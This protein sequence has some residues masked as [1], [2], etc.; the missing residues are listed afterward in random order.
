MSEH[1][2]HDACHHTHDHGHHHHRA[3]RSY[4]VAFWANLLFAIIEI[5]GGLLTQ[6][7]AITA[8]AVHDLGDATSIGVAWY[9]EKYSKKARDNA[10]NFGY[11]RFSLLAALFSGLV[12]V[13]G[14][15]GIAYHA[16]L[17]FSEP[18]QPATLGMLGLAV[19]GVV[20][21]GGSAL[22]IGAFGKNDGHTHSEK[23]LTWHFLEDLFGWVIVLIGAI[24]I[25]FTHWAWVDPLLALGLAIFIS[26][27]VIKN[28][29][30]TLFLL[31]QGRPR[32][33]DVRGLKEKVLAVKGV[34]EM[35][36]LQI[37]SL[38]GQESVLSM[39]VHLHAVEDRHEVEA[40]KDS[41]RSI[42]VRY[43]A[44][45]TTIETCLAE[46]CHSHGFKNHSSGDV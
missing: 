11:R 22:A 35:D 44:V 23:I 28:L 1:K 2:H 40:I 18:Q 43:G 4:A 29:K 21:N 10:F 39:R 31:L 26:W 8:D 32:G 34:A 9:L 16:L 7:L 20:V 41:V 42:S 45:Q 12:I 3:G 5:I 17:R 19:L 25:H 46:S 37:W 27:N 14:S 24:V 13:G 30:E 15:I 6:S 38:D 36:Q 33:F